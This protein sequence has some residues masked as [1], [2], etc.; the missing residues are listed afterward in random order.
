MHTKKIVE[1]VLKVPSK[2]LE[3]ETRLGIIVEDEWI[4]GNG[5]IQKRN[6]KELHKHLVEYFSSVASYDCPSKGSIIS[7][8][9]NIYLNS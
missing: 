8:K 3:K 6:R 4:Y 2:M 9:K 7:P 1:K 5:K